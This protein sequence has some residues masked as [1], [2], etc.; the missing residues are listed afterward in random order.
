M[1][2]RKTYTKPCLEQV[3]LALEEA[4]LAGCKAEIRAAGPAAVGGRPY[5]DCQSS[6]SE[7]LWIQT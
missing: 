7:C 2:K 4:V 5:G 1:E 3:Q 6:G